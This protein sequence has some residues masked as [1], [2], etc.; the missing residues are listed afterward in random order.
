MMKCDTG[1]IGPVLLLIAVGWLFNPSNQRN[2]LGQQLTSNPSR[3]SGEGASSSEQEKPTTQTQENL[4]GQPAD[5]PPEIIELLQQQAGEK[6]EL[7]TY[8]PPLRLGYRLMLL[9]GAALIMLAGI[10]ICRYLSFRGDIT[11]GENSLFLLLGFFGG[12]AAM[13]VGCAWVG[14]LY[15][16]LASAACTALSGYIITAF[17][18]PQFALMRRW[19]AGPP[20][21]K[22]S[23]G[24]NP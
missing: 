1:K 19:V 2:L 9:A 23:K 7:M 3:S 5:L 22:P 18:L 8:F 4:P 16:H 15:L 20:S 17:C 14:N 12:L 13:F 11:I 6:P 24:D 10:I 21:P